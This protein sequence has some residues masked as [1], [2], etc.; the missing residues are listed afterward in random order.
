MQI[1]DGRLPISIPAY[2]IVVRIS[3]LGDIVTIAGTAPSEIEMEVVVT[4]VSVTNKGMATL[5]RISGIINRTE[6]FKFS[7]KHVAP[8][9]VGIVVLR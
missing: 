1:E 6:C 8:S 4:V 9:S 3:T 2:L 5:F 7:L